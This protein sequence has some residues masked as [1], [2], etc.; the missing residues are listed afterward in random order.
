MSAPAGPGGIK[1]LSSSG[2]PCLHIASIG[3]L[4]QMCHNKTKLSQKIAEG[5]N[6]VIVKISE[7]H[8]A[9]VFL[10]DSVMNNQVKMIEHY[11]QLFPKGWSGWGIATEEEI[12]SGKALHNG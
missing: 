6:A 12:Q 1:D 7:S 8:S 10:S 2:R 11:D 4:H 5:M 3:F 9:L